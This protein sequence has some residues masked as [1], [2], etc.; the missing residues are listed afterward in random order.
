MNSQL[1]SRELQADEAGER[2]RFQINGKSVKERDL[3]V[4][5]EG[6]LLLGVESYG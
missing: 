2:F 6:G 4:V 5:D 3:D 1:R